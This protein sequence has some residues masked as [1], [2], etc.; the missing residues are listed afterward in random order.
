VYFRLFDRTCILIYVFIICYYKTAVRI[1][2]SIV[3]LFYIIHIS[4][5]QILKNSQNNIFGFSTSHVLTLVSC[6]ILF[7]TLK[8]EAIYVPPT[9]QAVSELLRFTIQKTRTLHSQCSE[10]LMFT[11]LC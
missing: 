1:T 11:I 5:L 6:E 2:L 4:V 10:N 3:V 8:M 7:S 9:C